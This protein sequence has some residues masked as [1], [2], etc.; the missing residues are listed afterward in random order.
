[1]AIIE[2]R[3]PDVKPTQSRIDDL[4]TAGELLTSQGI[5]ILPIKP[6]GKAPFLN[7][8]NGSWWIIEDPEDVAVVFRQ[9]LTAQR[10]CNLAMVCGR[11]KGSPVLVIDI[12]GPSGLA[13]ARELGVTSGGNCWVQR[14]G[15]GGWHIVYFA[16]AALELR[17]HVKPQGVDLDLIVDGYA[18]VEP[19]VTEKPYRWQQGHGPGDIGL[20]EVDSP[21]TALLEWWQEIQ[22]KEPVAAGEVPRAH[23]ACSWLK[24][25]IPQG[26]RN[27]TLTR[28]AGWLRLYH[29]EPVVALLLECV[30]QALCTPNPLPPKELEAIIKS[31]YKYP[32]PGVNGHP[33]AVVP[34]FVRA[35]EDIHA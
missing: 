18:L 28:V 15:G 23:S 3:N 2:K 35:P 7:P 1:M 20:A 32:Q 13:K 26:S 5:P 30:N 19:S 33:R 9:V 25:P 11:S 8:A 31:V 29:P 14:T 24:N 16:D 4:V 12:D 10:D 17:R 34:M 27:D 22:G 6:R 21:P